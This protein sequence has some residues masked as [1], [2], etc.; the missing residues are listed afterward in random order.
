MATGDVE[1]SQQLYIAVHNSP[2]IVDGE[3]IRGFHPVLT[4]H[5]GGVRVTAN[6]DSI[7]VHIDGPSSASEVES[8]ASNSG[9]N[10]SNGT[11]PSNERASQG[12]PGN[13]IVKRRRKKRRKKFINVTREIEY[14]SAVIGR[15]M[16]R[17]LTQS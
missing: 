6:V 7:D 4:P 15:R 16:H 17:Y 14:N 8:M 5:D 2:S 1:M 11:V 3:I 9:G 12:S 10:R 13:L